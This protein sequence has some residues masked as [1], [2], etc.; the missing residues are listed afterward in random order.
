VLSA[1][2]LTFVHTLGEFGV[3]LMIG[4]SIPGETKTIAIAIYDRVQAFDL[5]S[6]DR[7]ALLLLLLS[8]GAVAASFF[9]SARLALRR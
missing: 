6:A 4:G 2:V 1:I 9:A 7:M 8:L 5:A 3:V